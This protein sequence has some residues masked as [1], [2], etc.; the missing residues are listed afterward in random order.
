MLKSNDEDDRTTMDF[1]KHNKEASQHQ[2]QMGSTLGNDTR[3]KNG[4]MSTN[5]KND[6]NPL[7]FFD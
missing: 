3:F 7:I 2:L 1:S 4:F 5:S 6:Q